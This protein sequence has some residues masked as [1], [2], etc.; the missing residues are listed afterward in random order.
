[1]GNFQLKLG[2]RNQEHAYNCSM[3]KRFGDRIGTGLL[4]PLSQDC[5]WALL[6]PVS[7]RSN[8]LLDKVRDLRLH[9]AVFVSSGRKAL[10]FPLLTAGKEKQRQEPHKHLGSLSFPRAL[11]AGW[12]TVELIPK[13][14]LPTFFSHSKNFLW[15]ARGVN[16]NK[17]KVLA[18]FLRTPEIHKCIPGAHITCKFKFYSF[19]MKLPPNLE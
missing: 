18:G 5:I 10:F 3:G 12:T 8:E 16:G 9:H 15:P 13:E 2:I 1:M 4:T 19:C 7:L 17:M 11:P 14:M 6:F